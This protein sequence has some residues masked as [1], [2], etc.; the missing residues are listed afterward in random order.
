ML[1]TRLGL[2]AVLSLGSVVPVAAQGT[3]AD[4]DRALGLRKRYEALVGN[5]AEA[6]RWVGRTHKVY[7]RRTVKG[8]HDFILVDAD[9]KAKGPAF[10]HGRIAASLS[11]AA[12]KT[13]GALDLPFNAFDVVDNDRAI[14]FVADSATWRCDIATSTCRKATPQEAQQGGGGGRGGRGGGGQGG[15]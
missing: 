12:G 1:M 2:I 10:D 9:T 11:A 4:Y 15:C 7:Y 3:Q 13:Y 8:G 14:Q 5:A 6:P